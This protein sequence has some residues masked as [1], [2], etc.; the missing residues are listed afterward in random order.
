MKIKLIA[1]CCCSAF[2]SI[3][4]I[5]AGAA[6]ATARHSAPRAHLADS[7]TDCLWENAY[8]NPRLYIRQYPSTDAK[9]IY[10]ITWQGHFWATKYDMYN[11]GTHWV[12]LNSGG[13]A[14]AH[15]LAWIGGAREAY[16]YGQG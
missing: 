5:G 12:E 11:D 1:V 3:M 9:T 6:S 2:L 16:C 10:S 7:T 13:W 8:A 4:L 15:Y 14:N